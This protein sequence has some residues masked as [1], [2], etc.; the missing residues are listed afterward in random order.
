MQHDLVAGK[1]PGSA[2]P[3]LISP[4]GSDEPGATPM[5]DSTNLGLGPLSRAQHPESAGSLGQSP[6][7]GGGRGLQ[8]MRLARLAIANAAA[9]SQ[10]DLVSLKRT[11]CSYTLLTSANRHLQHC[12]Q[13]PGTQ[14]RL[15]S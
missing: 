9:L 12:N 1:T 7:M 8:P 13:V 11:A 3:L 2:L 5:H 6:A 4:A 14:A 10:Q 15:G